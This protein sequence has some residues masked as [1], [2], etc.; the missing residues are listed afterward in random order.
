MF[1]VANRVANDRAQTPFHCV[2]DYA[3][4]KMK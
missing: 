3:D 4:E 2:D 1:I